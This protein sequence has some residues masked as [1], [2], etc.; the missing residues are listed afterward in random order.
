M[1]DDLRALRRRK[2]AAYTRKRRKL[3]AYGR[4]EDPFVDPTK[5]REH[6]REIVTR[7]GISYGSI[8]RLGSFSTGQ[9]EQLMTP[10]HHQYPGRIRKET[11]A[12]ILAIR[13]DLDELDPIAWVAVD[14]TR[15]RL[16]ALARVG[17][18]QSSIAA[19]LGITGSAVGS[20]GSPGRRFVHVA[21]AIAVR[22]VY[23]R[24]SMK[25]GPSTKAVARAANRGWPPPWSWDDETLDDVTAEPDL[26]CLVRPANRPSEET[27]EEIRDLLRMDGTMTIGAIADRMRVSKDAISRA[28]TR[29]ID[30][31]RAAAYA[32][33]LGDGYAGPLRRDEQA[34]LDES[35]DEI[36]SLRERLYA[37]TEATGKSVSSRIAS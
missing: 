10:G 21:T 16:Q 26:A 17:W 18:P 14:G 31:R 25:L 5:A 37:N 30:Q 15:R 28:F 2:K 20:Y 22:E 11:E 29:T 6:V 34:D 3:I 8:A 19:E 33:A 12:S 27:L 9:I 36:L 13:F 7:Y 24:L 1:S 35:L 23:A 4:W 32:E